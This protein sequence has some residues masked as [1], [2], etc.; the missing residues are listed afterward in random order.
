MDKWQEWAETQNKFKQFFENKN[1]HLIATVSKPLMDFVWKQPYS[2]YVYMQYI[3]QA[4]FC[5]LNNK[6]CIYIS[7]SL[8]PNAVLKVYKGDRLGFTKDKKLI[9]AEAKEDNE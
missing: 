2:K 9:Y 5:W 7:S 3:L 4:G 8:E 1:G 6:N